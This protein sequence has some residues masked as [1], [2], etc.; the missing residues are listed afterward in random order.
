MTP[1]EAQLRLLVA[2]GMTAGEIGKAMRITRNAVL[3][4]CDRFGLKLAGPG[5]PRKKRVARPIPVVP[6]PF[7]SPSPPRQFSWQHP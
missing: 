2:Q 4:R 6:G 3:G 1:D 5:R 7:A